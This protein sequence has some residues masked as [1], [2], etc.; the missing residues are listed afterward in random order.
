MDVNLWWIGVYVCVCVWGGGGGGGVKNA[1][2]LL[3]LSGGGSKTLT[4]S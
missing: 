4:S 2:Q 1:Y 3:D